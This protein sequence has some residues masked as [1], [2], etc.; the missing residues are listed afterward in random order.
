MAATL[1]NAKLTRKIGTVP[2]V[3]HAFFNDTG[4][5]Y[6][7]KQADTVYKTLLAWFDNYL[8]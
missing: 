4:P 5:R 8:C 2:G 6:D 1:E 3:D 7:P